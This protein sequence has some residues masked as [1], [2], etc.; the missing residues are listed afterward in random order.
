MR[1]VALIVIALGGLLTA[2]SGAT[3][4]G[5][6]PVAP[7]PAGSVAGPTGTTSPTGTANATVPLAC[8]PTT[9]DPEFSAPSPYPVRPPGSYGSSWFGTRALWTMLNSDG[10]AWKGLPRDKVGY[11]Q[12]TFWWSADWDPAR[13]PAPAITVSG[14]QLDGPA[15]FTA[16]EG[17]S[18]TADFGT[19][20]L[21]GIVLP[22]PG[23]WQL[24]GRYRGTELTYVVWVDGN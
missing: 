20:M 2:C 14:R 11:S 9:P 7:P 23:C 10:E 6:T 16:S 13:E 17:T 4:V 8:H 3:P 18:A 22:S 19:A 5:S 24:T 12:K 1:R 21:V 15:T